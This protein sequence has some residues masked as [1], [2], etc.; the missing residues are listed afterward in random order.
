MF[1]MLAGL[2]FRE[3]QNGSR[4]DRCVVDRDRSMAKSAAA[5]VLS[6]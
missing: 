3:K 2:R 1:A 6:D 4:P 5:F